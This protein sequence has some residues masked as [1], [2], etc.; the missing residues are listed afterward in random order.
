[1]SEGFWVD[2]DGNVYRVD[3][4]EHI[5]F[6]RDAGWADDWLKDNPEPSDDSDD[7]EDDPYWDWVNA[8]KNHL[9]NRGYVRSR[10]YRGK[11][12]SDVAIQGNEDRM[13]PELIK[14]ILNA[15]KKPYDYPITIE[16]RDGDERLSKGKLDD[17]IKMNDKKYL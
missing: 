1:M 14:K 3:N 4:D 15:H 10:L 8:F 9:Y 17:W 5:L 2:P 11:N 13:T 16:V 7:W 12:L 6:A